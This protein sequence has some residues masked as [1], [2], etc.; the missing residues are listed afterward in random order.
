MTEDANH[1]LN[2]VKLRLKPRHGITMYI[3]TTRLRT[4][5]RI[6][7]TLND[8]ITR[9]QLA[10]HA[11]DRYT[12]RHAH[13]QKPHHTAHDRQLLMASAATN[14]ALTLIPF[15]ALTRVYWGR[16]MACTDQK[17]GVAVDVFAT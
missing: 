16:R 9:H 3:V 4:T 1:L 11:V 17:M 6:T 10:S 5:G 7:T 14:L 12:G 8:H 2:A 15:S 13:R